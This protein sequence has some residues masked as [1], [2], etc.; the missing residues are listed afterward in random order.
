MSNFRVKFTIFMHVAYDV[1][2]SLK[3]AIKIAR[4]DLAK[5]AFSRLYPPLSPMTHLTI[6]SLAL[7][8]R[9]RWRQGRPRTSSFVPTAFGPF[10]R[11]GTNDRGRSVVGPPPLAR[12]LYSRSA[13]KRLLSA[14]RLRVNESV[15][16]NVRDALHYR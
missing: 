3:N 16:S 1:F 10:Q 11:W 13:H 15:F 8:F 7:I 14:A 9:N 12:L 5:S 4:A 6:A 2:T